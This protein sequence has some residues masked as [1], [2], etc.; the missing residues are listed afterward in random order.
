MILAAALAFLTP[1]YRRVS[2]EY[3]RAAAEDR[4]ARERVGRRGSSPAP[5]SLVRPAPGMSPGVAALISGGEDAER[6]RIGG[7]AGR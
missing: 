3:A 7:V 6:A 4:A 2:A 5:A 1:V